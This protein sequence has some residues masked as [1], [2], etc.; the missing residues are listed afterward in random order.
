VGTAVAGPALSKG[1][2]KKIAAKVVTKAAPSLSVAHATTATTA[3]SADKLAGQPA[4]RYLDQVA[5]S[6]STTALAVPTGAVTQILNPVAITIPAG[7][8]FV[9]VNVAASFVGG[10][11]LVAAWFQVD[12]VCLGSGSDW[13]YRQFGHTAQQSTVALNRVVPVTPGV[14]TFRLCMANAADVNAE[15][16]VL[17]VETVAI[18]G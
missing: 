2:V 10:S 17:T 15:T 8:G 14:H 4:S 9:H 5:Q 6:A 16:R 1:K 13:N 3:T 18:A 11:T 7:V 12:S